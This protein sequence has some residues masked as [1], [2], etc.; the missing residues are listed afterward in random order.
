[1]FIQFVFVFSLLFAFSAATNSTTKGGAAK[2]YIFDSELPDRLQW[3]DNDGYCGE[4]SCVMA[5]LKSGAYLSQY[6]VREIS[7][8][9]STDVQK[10]RFYLVGEND[11]HASELLKLGYIEYDHDVFDSKV[12]LSWVKQMVRKGYSVTIT[13]YMNNWLFYGMTDPDAGFPDYDHIVSVKDVQSDYDD[14]QYHDDDIITMSDHGLWAPEVPGP[15]YPYPFD[16]PYYFSYTFK[17]F[18]MTRQDANKKTSGVY[19]LPISSPSKNYAG[20]FGI[21]HTGPADTE[22]S[23]Q[24]ISITT[25]VNYESPQIAK[26]SEVRPTPMEITLVVTVSAL[27][28]GTSYNLYKYKDET[29]VPTSNFNAHKDQASSTMIIVGVKDTPFVLTEKIMSNQ[30]VYYRCVKT[31]AN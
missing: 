13:V 2:K 17:E 18:Q 9:S 1:M 8:V 21:A 14:D 4:V 28:A 27:E 19:A 6:D 20:N 25:N 3:I 23:L 16:A 10:S 29:S 22:G 15:P 11:Q 30:K 24:K 7:A 31:T 12:Y 5:L 26:R